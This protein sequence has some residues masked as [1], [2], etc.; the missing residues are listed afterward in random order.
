MW[1]MFPYFGI[2]T[3]VSYVEHGF[4]MPDDDAEWYGMPATTRYRLLSVPLVSQFHIDFW[5]MRLLFNVGAFG[6]YRFGANYK[7]DCYDIRPDYGFIGGGGLAVRMKPFE[8]HLECNYQY[9]LSMLFNPRKMSNAYF[10]YVYPHH[11]T[12]SFGLFFQLG[13]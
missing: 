5:K 4:S 11:L 6:G 7:Y 8:F 9:S 1:K 12:F 10:I 3:G 2:Q 13:R